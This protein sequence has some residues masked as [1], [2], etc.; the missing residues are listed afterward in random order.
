MECEIGVNTL[1]DI[2][3][4]ESDFNHRDVE[5]GSVIRAKVRSGN[6]A[7]ERRA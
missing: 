5:A 3:A 4:R 7:G 2:G 6:G 1:V